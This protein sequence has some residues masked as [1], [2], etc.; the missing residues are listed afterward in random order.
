[1]GNM[2]NKMMLELASSQW[3]RPRLGQTEA[4]GGNKRP[5]EAEPRTER[6]VRGRG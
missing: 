5:R 1:M 6:E 2:K 3:G 4:G